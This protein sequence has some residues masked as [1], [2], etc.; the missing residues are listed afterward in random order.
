MS[1]KTLV[2]Q[3]SIAGEQVGCGVDEASPATAVNG[4]EALVE[5]VPPT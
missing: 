1:P 2:A 5:E 3:G 4:D